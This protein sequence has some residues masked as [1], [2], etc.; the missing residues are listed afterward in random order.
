MTK[1]PAAAEVEIDQYF[2][3][4]RENVVY[5]HLALMQLVSVMKR[6]E[7]R[8]TL[9]PT[10]KANLEVQERALSDMLVLG[11][12]RL[13]DTGYKSNR[14]QLS[15]PNLL[16]SNSIKREEAHSHRIEVLISNS[17]VEGIRQIRTKIVAHS[18]SHASNASLG[19][20]EIW[21]IIDDCYQIISDI[22]HHNRPSQQLQRADTAACKDK[23]VE[24]TENW[25]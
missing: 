7:H 1:K 18:L 16:E 12:A 6:L 2:D 13:F 21:S 19:L 4:L 8:E 15:L 24:M 17:T 23:W 14:D 5:A 25:K 22:Y 11:V 3:K 10:L 9:E 20:S